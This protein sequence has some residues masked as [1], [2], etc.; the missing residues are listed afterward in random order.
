MSECLWLLMDLTVQLLLFIQEVK[1]KHEVTELAF[2]NGL[3][4]TTI[5]GDIFK[6]VK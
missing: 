2:T 1:A 3:H 4:G 6:E 5:N